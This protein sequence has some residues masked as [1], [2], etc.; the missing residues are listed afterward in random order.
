MVEGPVRRYRLQWVVTALAD[1]VALTWNALSADGLGL[2]L[3]AWPVVACFSDE[4]DGRLDSKMAAQVVAED[5]VRTLVRRRH[6]V[7]RAVVRVVRADRRLM[8]SNLGGVVGSV[9]VGSGRV[10]GALPLQ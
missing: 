6:G 8:G 7:C 4:V 5:H 9:V 10:A 2:C 3:D 1:I